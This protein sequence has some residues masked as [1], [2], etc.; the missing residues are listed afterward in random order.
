ME[1]PSSANTGLI[2]L[3]RERIQPILMGGDFHRTTTLPEDEALLI[4]L[5]GPTLDCVVARDDPKEYPR[6]EFLRVQVENEEEI[7]LFRVRERFAP[8]T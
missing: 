6:F 8:R 5:D 1:S 7:Y 2:G 4:S 3:A